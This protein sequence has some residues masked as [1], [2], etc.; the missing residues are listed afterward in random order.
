ML[1]GWTAPSIHLSLRPAFDAQ[2][3]LDLKARRAPL[4]PG[5][6]AAPPLIPCC[7]PALVPSAEPPRCR[8]QANGA[9]SANEKVGPTAHCRKRCRASGGQRPPCSNRRPPLKRTRRSGACPA[10][11]A[12][13]GSQ[14]GAGTGWAG[15]AAAPPAPPAVQGRAAAS[16]A[17]PTTG[18]ATASAGAGARAAATA[19]AATAAHIS[20]GAGAAQLPCAGALLRRSGRGCG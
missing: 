12:K 17:P 8:R 6:H 20:T 9:G 16:G 11:S 14:G 10:A 2:R 13:H 18:T 19:S 4:Q 1:Y 7:L 3:V 15:S 5:S